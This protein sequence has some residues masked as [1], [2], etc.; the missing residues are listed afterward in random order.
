[1]DKPNIDYARAMLLMSV[2]EKITTVAPRQTHILGMAMA[3]LV[4]MDE[5]AHA[6]LDEDT[7]QKAKAQRDTDAKRVAEA[8]AE[9]EANQPASGPKAIP[10]TEFNEPTTDI[11][12]APIVRRPVTE[13]V[14]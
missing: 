6:W 14:V 11:A 12:S 8:T 3:E 5:V 13:E 2:V 10:A 4:E 9:N 7:K 1:M